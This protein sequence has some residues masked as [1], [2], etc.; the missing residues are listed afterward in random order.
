[1]RERSSS[2]LLVLDAQRRVLLFRFENKRGP[3]A[4]QLF[5]AT[6][7]GAVEQ[8]ET[9]EE[10]AR[11][12]IFEETGLQID[13]VG[14]QVGQRMASFRLTTG[15]TVTA[16][17][18]FFAVRLDTLRVSTEGWTELEH[19][20]VTENRWWSQ[21]ELG[22]ATEQIWPEDLAR[23]LIDAGIWDPA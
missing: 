22:S 7:G 16:D 5:W 11:R 9:F 18:R 3:L 2:R 4:G 23:M 1:M 10:A 15:D 6:P 21:A 20:V 13:D 12:E 17:E 14:P 19:E 8:G